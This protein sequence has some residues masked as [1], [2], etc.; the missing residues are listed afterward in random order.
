MNHSN[1]TF[2]NAI[3]KVKEERSKQ[4]DKW[5]EQDHEA[6]VWLVILFEEIGELAQAVLHDIFGDKATSTLKT[7]LLH[8]AAISIQW[9]ESIERNEK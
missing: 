3:L 4:N 9:L 7:E 6:D 5:G 8:V 1:S 2:D